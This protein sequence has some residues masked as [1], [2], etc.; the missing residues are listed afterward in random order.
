MQLISNHDTAAKAV[1]DSRQ[2]IIQEGRE[3]C[4][5]KTVPFRFITENPYPMGTVASELWRKGWMEA[6]D[7]LRQANP[8][9]F[10]HLEALVH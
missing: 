4:L 9:F 6:S 8:A 2:A 5:G 3:A 1:A 7:D 10:R